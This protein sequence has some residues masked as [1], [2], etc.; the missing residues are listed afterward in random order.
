VPC[1]I[2]QIGH[3]SRGQPI[4][5]PAATGPRAA[6]AL[7]PPG[8]LQI[9]AP[10]VSSAAAI[11]S[12][13]FLLAASHATELSFFILAEISHFAAMRIRADVFAITAA[14]YEESA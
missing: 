13:S 7:S 9:E 14:D 5:E 12:L 8:R 10:A 3:I 4:A 6:I 2:L 1:F 11:F